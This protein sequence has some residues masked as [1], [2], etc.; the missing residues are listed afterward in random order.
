MTL[1]RERLTPTQWIVTDDHGNL[2]HVQV[3]G[4]Y[5][6]EDDSGKDSVTGDGYEQ[7]R[8]P[9]LEAAMTAAEASLKNRLDSES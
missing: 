8:H 1:R 7:T 4:P 6:G 3:L 2:R 5:I 9:T